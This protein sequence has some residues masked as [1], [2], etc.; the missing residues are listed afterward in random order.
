MGFPPTQLPEQFYSVLGADTMPFIREALEAHALAIAE[1]MVGT[2]TGTLGGTVYREYVTAWATNH[3]YEL[4]N[5]LNDNTRQ[6]VGDVITKYLETPGMTR[7]DVEDLLNES[8]AFTP[9]RA[10][11]IAVTETTAATSAGTQAAVEEARAAGL[12][13]TETW[14]TQDGGCEEICAP[15][16]GTVRGDGWD[17]DPPAHP[18]CAC[19]VTME[20]A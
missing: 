1:T 8:G 19:W 7:Q 15:L 17:E 20:W 9:A 12:E 4:S 5:Y 10:S 11:M 2:I 6:I 14:R 18:N 16:D 13:V 3:A